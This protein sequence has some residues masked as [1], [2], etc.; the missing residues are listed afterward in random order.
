MIARGLMN[1]N[2]G[3]LRKSKD[4]WQGLADKQ[5]DFQFFQFKSADF[6]IRALATTLITYQDKYNI[7][8]IADIINRWAPPE[9]NDTGSYASSVAIGTG[10][11]KYAVLDL[12]SYEH[13]EPI[14]KAIIK[15]ENGSMPYEQEVINRGLAMA[16]VEVPKKPLSK[17]KTI[18]GAA[19]SATGTVGAT[20]SSLLEPIVQ[21]R[22]AISPLMQYVDIAKYAFLALVLIGV[23]ITVYA[24]VK[25]NASR[26]A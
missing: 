5:T 11:G 4:Q 3:N 23:A 22:D 8:C 16:G 10:F 21:A 2:P 14:V 19:V 20:A 24:R 17:S 6:G 7:R 13:L 25:D 15:H 1:S 26:I 18:Q 12:H 9:E